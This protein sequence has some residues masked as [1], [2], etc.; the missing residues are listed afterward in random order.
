MHLDCMPSLPCDAIAAALILPCAFALWNLICLIKGATICISSWHANS[1]M[2]IMGLAGLPANL[3][4][5]SSG[6]GAQRLQEDMNDVIMLTKRFASDKFLIQDSGFSKVK[7][8]GTWKIDVWCVFDLII[9]LEEATLA[10]P[11]A[12]QRML[13]EVPR[14]PRPL[15]PVQASKKEHYLQLCH[16]LL[17]KSATESTRRSV[18]FLVSRQHIWISLPMQHFEHP[19]CTPSC[20]LLYVCTLLVSLPW[21]L[22]DWLVLRW[23]FALAQLQHRWR[24]CHGLKALLR[25]TVIFVCCMRLLFASVCCL[26]RMLLTKVNLQ[27]DINAQLPSALQR[28]APVMRFVATLNRR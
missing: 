24:I 17:E 4:I 21:L 14:V 19:I 20:N 1:K 8:F 18:E 28:L 13:G 22:G 10:L 15:K 9:T 3:E 27:P 12:Y 23:T 26:T 2:C 11:K 7:V 6:R 16:L 5:V 25:C